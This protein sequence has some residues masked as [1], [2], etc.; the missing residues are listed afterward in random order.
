MMN[1]LPKVGARVYWKMN[2]TIFEGVVMSTRRGM[3]RL[4]QA[5]CWFIWAGL[6]REQEDY[7]FYFNSSESVVD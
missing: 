4:W 6:A 7:K 5:P 2:G 3:V 1:H